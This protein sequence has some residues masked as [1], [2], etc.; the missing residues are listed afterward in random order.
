LFRVLV[1]LRDG[2][3]LDAQ[4]E[5]MVTLLSCSLSLRLGDRVVHRRWYC[6]TI[7]VLARL[8]LALRLLRWAR[9]WRIEDILSGPVEEARLRWLGILCRLSCGNSIGPVVGL[10]RLLVFGGD[11]SGVLSGWTLYH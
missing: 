9:C 5:E 6:E 7:G 11:V 3:I 8:F 1:F 2:L 10:L 4:F